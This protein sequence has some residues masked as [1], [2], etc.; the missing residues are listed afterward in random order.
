MPGRRRANKRMAKKLPDAR[1]AQR[2]RHLV[3]PQKGPAG[4]FIG[5]GAGGP[6]RA[7]GLQKD[8]RQGKEKAWKKTPDGPL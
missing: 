1:E 3:R 7:E 8:E 6:R 5:F 2:P 4:A